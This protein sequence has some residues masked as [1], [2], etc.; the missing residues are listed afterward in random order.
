MPTSAAQQ[1]VHVTPITFQP[2]PNLIL[3]DP[4]VKSDASVSTVG[5]TSVIQTQ[6]QPS[7]FHNL[8]ATVDASVLVPRSEPAVTHLKT[9]DAKTS[10]NLTVTN[11]VAT[12][13]P[14]QQTAANTGLSSTN[15]A[16]NIFDRMLDLVPPVTATRNELPSIPA[17]AVSRKS[18][19][20][21]L[22]TLNDNIMLTTEVVTSIQRL[23]T[24]PPEDTKTLPVLCAGDGDAH[25]R[26]ASPDRKLNEDRS[27]SHPLVAGKRRT[28]GQDRKGNDISNKKEDSGPAAKKAKRGKE[29]ESVKSKDKQLASSLPSDLK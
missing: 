7:G 9:A 4:R 10:N 11:L 1:Q 19:E 14:S 29:D 8:L 17:D 18:A 27:S 21:Q 28:A 6:I 26:T 23:A 22:T 2:T 25:K 13:L 3:R 12:S 20:R 5:S 15:T 24:P 16:S